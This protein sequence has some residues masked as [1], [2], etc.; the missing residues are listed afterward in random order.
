MDPQVNLPNYVMMLLVLCQNIWDVHQFGLFLAVQVLGVFPPHKVHR[1]RL[2]KHSV[3]GAI[4]SKALVHCRH[5]ELAGKNTAL[6]QQCLIIFE[7]WSIF[8]AQPGFGKHLYRWA[9]F[10]VVVNIWVPRKEKMCSRFE[11]WTI[12]LSGFSAG[13][14]HLGERSQG[15]FDRIGT[16]GS[17][18]ADEGRSLQPTESGASR[19]A[20]FLNNK[21]NYQWRKNTLIWLFYICNLLPFNT[22]NDPICS[23]NLES[24]FSRFFSVL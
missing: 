4:E 24:Q 19:T 1:K 11:W 16:R 10:D 22:L 6:V 7:L 23:L 14:C 15:S 12:I 13:S 5:Q 17:M 3:P 21:T 8:A 18:P 9:T 2:S 20:S